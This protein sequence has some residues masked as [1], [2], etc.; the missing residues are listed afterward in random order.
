MNEL[1]CNVN[2]LVTDI[3]QIEQYPQSHRHDVEDADADGD[4]SDHEDA[5]VDGD[6]RN[7]HCYKF[8]RRGMGGNNHGNNDPFATIKFSLPPFARNV[9]PEAYLDLELVV[10]QKLDSHNVLAEYI[11]RL[12]TSEFTNFSLFWR[13][14]LCNAHNAVVVPQTWNALKQRKK[15]R[16]APPYYQCDLCLKLQ[17]LKQ[18]DKGVKAYYQELLVGLGHCGVNEDD[19]DA[20][21]RFFGGLNHDIQVILDYKECHNFFQLYYLAIKAERE[22]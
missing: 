2:N 10:Q 15:S 5:D 22:V 7:H 13:S 21:V 14:D 3:E 6:A 20:S 12:V 8:N 4:L 17:T 19:A 9:D 16:F 11:V 18:G 1:M